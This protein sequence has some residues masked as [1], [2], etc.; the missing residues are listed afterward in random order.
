MSCG[1]LE[2]GSV[3]RLIQ[4]GDIQQ[5]DWYVQRL[6]PQSKASYH[7]LIVHATHL[8]VP[9]YFKL[10]KK[11]LC[12]I[13]GIFYDVPRQYQQ[14]CSI[15]SATVWGVLLVIPLLC[16]VFCL[17]GHLNIKWKGDYNFAIKASCYIA[18]NIKIQKNFSS[19]FTLPD[20]L[21]ALW[22]TWNE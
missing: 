5:S 11:K 20:L 7:L 22:L 10:F 14:S 12:F 8:P 13:H 19:Y 18:W 6:L 3:R 4:A 21:I 1:C 9:K 15:I 16:V 17:T 2:T